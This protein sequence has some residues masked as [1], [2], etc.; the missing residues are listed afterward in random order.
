MSSRQT[1]RIQITYIINSTLDFNI[2]D[3]INN[4]SLTKNRLILNEN[5]K[6]NKSY[7]NYISFFLGSC[8]TISEILPLTTDSFHGITHS[9]K[10][11]YNINKEYKN[12]F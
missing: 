11:L 4:Y 2:N 7:S 8:L 12:N 3:I 10:I 1:K 6:T 9:I 5:K